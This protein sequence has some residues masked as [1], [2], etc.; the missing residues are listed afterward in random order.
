MKT[1]IGEAISLKR[2]R[3]AFYF[4]AP[5]AGKSHHHKNEEMNARAAFSVPWYVLSLKFS[6]LDAFEWVGYSFDTF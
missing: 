5:R 1:N 4:I 6:K 3:A 2:A